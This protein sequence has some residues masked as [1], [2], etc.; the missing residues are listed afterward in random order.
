MKRLLLVEL[1]EFSVELFSKASSLLKLPGITRLLSMNHT[2]TWTDDN[3][4]RQGL[5]PWVQ[6]VSVHSGVDSS[7]HRIKHLGDIPQLSTRQLWEELSE[8]GLSCGVWGAMNAARGGASNCRFFLPD[9]W[10][11][12]EQA[13]PEKL[14]ALL[15]FPR[16]YSKNYLDIDKRVALNG[17]LR[18]V[19]FVITSGAL[20]SILRRVPLILKGILRFGLSSHVLFSVFDLVLTQI[21]IRYK[22]V[23][24]TQFSLIFLNSIAHL[25]HNIWVAGEPNARC[26]YSIKIIDCILSDLFASVGDNEEI[27]IMNALSQENVAGRKDDVLYRQKNPSEFLLSTGIKYLKVEQLMTNDSHVIFDTAVD[28]EK[29]YSA[30]KLA[31][32]NGDKMFDVDYDKK[33]PFKLF[34]QFSLWK[35]I[36]QSATFNLNGKCYRFYDHFEAVVTRTGEH[37]QQGDV[38]TSTLKLPPKMY[39]HKMY[40]SIVKFFKELQ[41]DD[42]LV[43]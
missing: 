20:L 10:T 17:L 36:P 26:L 25:Q 42:F 40:H 33:T 18:L 34:F 43:E 37:I 7:E 38:Y 22:K 24:R 31:E 9:P 14:N 16:Y 12:S 27:V 29:A 8:R 21:F 15:D 39:N 28:A 2:F 30:L 6:W 19:W 32:V 5:D 35:R 3:V 41:E 4:E 23:E 11:Y 1:N 13:Y